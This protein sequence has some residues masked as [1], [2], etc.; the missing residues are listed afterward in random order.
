MMK[1]VESIKTVKEKSDLQY[2]LE[3]IKSDSQGESHFEASKM[4]MEKEF[5]EL[6]DNRIVFIAFEGSQP[7]ACAQLLLKNADND[8]ELADG[9]TT[10][11]VHNLR[12]LRHRR[13]QGIGER[14]MQHIEKTALLM[15]L[16]K[17]TLGVDDYNESALALYRKLNYTLLKETQGQTPEEKCFYL[18]KVLSIS[19]R[20]QSSTS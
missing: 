5:E 7:I 16:E 2:C 13:R 8:P 19:S 15:G 11:H 20:S 14:M 1:R 18:I 10:A 9:S 17:L 4:E 3:I 6:G 12:V